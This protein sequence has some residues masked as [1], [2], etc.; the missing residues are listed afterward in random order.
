[1]Q[2]WIQKLKEKKFPVAKN[3]REA[4]EIIYCEGPHQSWKSVIA[5]LSEGNNRVVYKFH[6]TGTHAAVGSYS[7]GDPGEVF[8]L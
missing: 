7:S 4:G 2:T 3:E 5:A 6:G 1:M 8:E